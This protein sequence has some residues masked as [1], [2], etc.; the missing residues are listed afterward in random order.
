MIHSATQT[1]KFRKFV[2][3]LRA[4]VDSEVVELETIAV[5]LLERLWHATMQEAKRGDIGRHDNETIADMMGWRAQNFDALIAL[6]VE[7]G[8]LDECAEHRLIVHD[9]AEHCPAFIKKNIGRQGGFVEPVSSSKTAQMSQHAPKP[10]S[11][12][13]EN[14]DLS[15]NGS[16]PNQTKHNPT[17]PDPTQPAEPAFDFSNP[18]VFWDTA[19]IGWMA[20]DWLGCQGEFIRQ[21]NG[22]AGGVIQSRLKAMPSDAASWFRERWAS[23]EWRKLCREA[24]Q[25]LNDDRGLKS[26]TRLA[27]KRWLSEESLVSDVLGGRYDFM[28]GQTNG[29]KPRQGV[30]ADDY[31]EGGAEHIPAEVIEA[32]HSRGAKQMPETKSGL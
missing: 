6:M 25:K 3:R 16:T 19:P 29:R 9:W 8:W 15:Q 30:R 2:R 20:F 18:D 14:G 1:S 11:H 4:L 12:E 17:E 13:E 28:K 22:L 31:R 21:W 23:E 26:G 10:S 32:S 27:L 24:F 5:G 7:S